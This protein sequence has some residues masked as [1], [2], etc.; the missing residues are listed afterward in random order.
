M[1]Q[2]DRVFERVFG[3]HSPRPHRDRVSLAHRI[4]R[5]RGRAH[6]HRDREPQNLTDPQRVFR[7]LVASRTG[8]LLNVVEAARRSGLRQEVA[9]RDIAEL[10]EQRKIMLLPAHPASGIE[11]GRRPPKLHVIDLGWLATE[12]GWD[13][14]GQ[15]MARRGLGALVETAV[16]AEWAHL[17]HRNDEEPDFCYW[18]SGP[19]REIDLVIQRDGLLHA[20]E[21]KSTHLPVNRH[22]DGIKS[23]FGRWQKVIPAVVACRTEE[24][25]DLIYGI[26]AV[27]WHLD[28]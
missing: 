15:V 2:I 8:Q 21:V 4:L 10:L 24:P 13:S 6:L 11:G 20:V 19:G 3:D 18:A 28:W 23:W 5:A 16:V 22:A 26:R 25:V 1:N 14:S 9:R 27:P 12:L 7:R 17:F